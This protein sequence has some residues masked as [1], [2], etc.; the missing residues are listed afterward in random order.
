MTLMALIVAY[1]VLKLKAMQ[2][3]YDTFSPQKEAK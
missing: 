2:V 1:G 3:E